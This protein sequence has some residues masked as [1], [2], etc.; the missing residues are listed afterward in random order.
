MTA[1]SHNI[2]QLEYYSTHFVRCPRW[3]FA[4]FWETWETI[5][6]TQGTIWET[7]E[8]IQDIGWEIKYVLEYI[9]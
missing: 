5:W 4:I 7:W 2:D 8:T 6:E 3:G 9:G 1:Y